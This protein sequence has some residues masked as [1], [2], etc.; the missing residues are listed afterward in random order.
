MTRQL[1]TNLTWRKST[2][3]GKD[4]NCVEMA[5]L[6]DSSV[7]VRDS[8][9]PHGPVLTFSGPAWSALL[10]NIDRGLLGSA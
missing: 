9:V 5:H 2:H 10:S 8:K 4:G 3:S 7:G 6:D 1:N